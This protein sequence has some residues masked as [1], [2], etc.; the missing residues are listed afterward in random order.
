MLFCKR[1]WFMLPKN[2]R[3]VV[4]A[5]YRPGQEIDKRPS[6]EYLDAATQA[7]VYVAKKEGIEPDT[8][9]YDEFRLVASIK[10]AS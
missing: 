9:L 1:H 10:G 8:S 3:D 7:V 4:W 2:L 6:I 5:T